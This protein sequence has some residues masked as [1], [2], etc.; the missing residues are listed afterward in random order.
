M[1]EIYTK[2][3]GGDADDGLQIW[4]KTKG[5]AYVY[6]GPVKKLILFLQN[7]VSPYRKHTFIYGMFHIR[8]VALQKRS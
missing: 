4:A 7:P 5:P 2:I 3:Y 1:Y 6:R 8:N